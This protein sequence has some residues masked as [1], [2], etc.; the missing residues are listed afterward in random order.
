MVVIVAV[1]IGAVVGGAVVVGAVVGGAVEV[2][3]VVDGHSRHS[4]QTGH[5]H[6]VFQSRSLSTHH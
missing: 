1:V 5:M 6:F 3:A 4:T 2:V